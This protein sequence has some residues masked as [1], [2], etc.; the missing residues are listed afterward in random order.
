MYTRNIYMYTEAFLF[1]FRCN[2]RV[3]EPC[4]LSPGF[5]FL[6]FLCVSNSAAYQKPVAKLPAFFSKRVFMPFRLRGDS[7][8]ATKVPV[9]PIMPATLGRGALVA[10]TC[11]TKMFLVLIKMSQMGQS[12]PR[13]QAKEPRLVRQPHVCG[14]PELFIF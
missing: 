10:R 14:L 11:P 4:A 13:V 8:T 2:N 1:F 5:L 7:T 3:P 12:V 9:A 6:L